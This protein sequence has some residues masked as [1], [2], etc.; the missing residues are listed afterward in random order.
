MRYRP[1]A[2]SRVTMTKA[3]AD[4]LDAVVNA[5]REVVSSGP[6]PGGGRLILEV[7]VQRLEKALA[8]LSE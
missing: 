6:A 7:H 8:E 1:N 2:T 3:E 5:A 4:A